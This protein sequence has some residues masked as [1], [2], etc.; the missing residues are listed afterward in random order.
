MPLNILLTGVQ[1]AGKLIP[2]ADFPAYRARHLTRVLGT[3]DLEIRGN[4][5]RSA[6]FRAAD[7]DSFIR[8]VCRWGNY[9]GI[10]GRVLKRNVMT[11]L[12]DQFNAATSLLN[13][14]QASTDVALAA[15]NK[16]KSL[17]TPSFASKHLRFLRPDICPVL[18]TIMSIR[19]GY[20]FTPGGYKM[21][22]EHCLT[23]AR[24]LSSVSPLAAADS[25]VARKT[26]GAADVE[27]AVFAFLQ[28]W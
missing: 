8:E 19:A 15:I 18:D 28:G 7:L 10:A 9:P 12:Q 13:V 16:I 1:V 23:V 14:D 27:M 5:L 21:F 20:A 4:N 11:T 26:W 6:S 22:S 24:V 3:L 2:F 25:E 17:G